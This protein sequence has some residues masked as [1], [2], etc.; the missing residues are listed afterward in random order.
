MQ[1]VSL[2]A[3]A[4]KQAEWISARQQVA[5]D[6]IANVNTV[7]YRAKAVVDF[8]SVLAGKNPTME[9]TNARHFTA[10]EV[11]GNSSNLIYEREAVESGEPRASLTDEMIAAGGIQKDYE[12]NTAIVKSFHRMILMTVRS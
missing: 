1:P 7:G 12:L 9:S 4:S 11:N 5:A 6:N 3:L 10:A 8:S 2:F